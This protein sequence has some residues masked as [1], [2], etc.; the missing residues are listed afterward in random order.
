MV[1]SGSDSSIIEI[2]DDSPDTVAKWWIKDLGLNESDRSVLQSGNELTENIV[3]AA[4]KILTNQFPKFHGF[5]STS[6]I[7]HLN[8]KEIPSSTK[9]VQILH[10]GI[11]MKFI[12]CSCDLIS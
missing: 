7:H 1:E 11:I 3:N 2:N 12:P 9:S 5:Q 8:F 10:T 6:L 4:Q